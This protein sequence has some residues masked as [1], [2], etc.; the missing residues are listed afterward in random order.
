K[1]FNF[2]DKRA[3]GQIIPGS[4]PAFP[5][6]KPQ[7]TLISYYGRLNYALMDKYLLTLNVR[8]D[9]SSRFGVDNRWGIFPSAAF[10]W[11]ISDEN[12]LKNSK[13][14]SDLKLRLGYGVTGQQDGIA[15]YG[16]IPNYGLSN[17][18][19][20]YQFGNTYYNMYRPNAYDA[21]L[22]W[23]QTENTNIAVDF[24]FA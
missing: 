4:N 3:N 13:V 17:N 19:A 21:N 10:A 2:A 15:Y 5:I 14:V 20:Q 23:E 6:D 7:Y 18:T 16:Y 12:F 8:T 22:K 9:G 24:G 1:N 11:K